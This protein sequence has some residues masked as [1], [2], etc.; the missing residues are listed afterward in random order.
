MLNGRNRRHSESQCWGTALRGC[1]VEIAHGKHSSPMQTNFRMHAS[2]PPLPFCTIF[3]FRFRFSV[4]F[5]YYIFAWHHLCTFRILF[6]W[7]CRLVSNEESKFNFEIKFIQNGWQCCTHTHTVHALSSEQWVDGRIYADSQRRANERKH[8]LIHIMN[9][10][11]YALSKLSPFFVGSLC[12]LQP[13]CSCRCRC[14]CTPN[15]FIFISRIFSFSFSF[16]LL[17]NWFLFQCSLLRVAQVRTDTD[18]NTGNLSSEKF[19]IKYIGM[20]SLVT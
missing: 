8:C 16:L 3:H 14:R 1:C 17:I 2:L 9:K 11:F 18:A 6:I 5:C 15:S 19:K 12:T 7:N 20:F 13:E 4:S 10:L